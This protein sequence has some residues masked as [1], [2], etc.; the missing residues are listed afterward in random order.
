[1]R[2][3]RRATAGTLAAA[4]AWIVASPE[5]TAQAAAIQPS[6]SDGLTVYGEAD[7]TWTVRPLDGD[8]LSLEGFR[9]EVLFINLWASWC[10]PCI[11]EMGS[12]ERLQERL[13]D[14]DVRFL[15]VAA[16]DERAVRR[17]LRRYSYDL[18]IY[19]EIDRIPA[20]FGLR[21]LPS[22]WI[23]DRRGRIVL[24]RHGEAVWDTDEVER[25]VRAVASP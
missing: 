7:Y 14:T 12:I 20:A 15:V 6:A 22:S 10:L 4:C 25:F 3:A 16:D 17:H 18:P 24:F 23:V 1:M 2:T 5:A 9:G 13:V 19:L 21:G 11:R 8:P